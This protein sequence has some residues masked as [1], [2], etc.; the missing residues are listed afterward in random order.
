MILIKL[1]KQ[2]SHMKAVVPSISTLMKSLSAIHIVYLVKTGGL[3][4][5]LLIWTLSI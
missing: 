4:L 5:A 2:D 1:L 3:L